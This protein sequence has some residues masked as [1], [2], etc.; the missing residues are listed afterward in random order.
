VPETTRCRTL[1]SQEGIDCPASNGDRLLG[2]HAVL[3]GPKATQGVVLLETEKGVLVDGLGAAH[4]IRG[5]LAQTILPRLIKLLDGTHSV[6]DLLAAFPTIPKQQ[7]ETAITLLTEWKL[8]EDDRDNID[9]PGVNT[10]TLAFLKRCILVSKLQCSAAQAYARLQNAQVLIVASA[11][12]IVPADYVRLLV[13]SSGIGSVTMTSH[14]NLR[15]ESVPQGTLLVVL[16]KENP[17][18]FMDLE[19]WKSVRLISWLRATLDLEGG[20]ADVGPIFKPGNDTCYSCFHNVYSASVGS[21]IKD[22]ADTSLSASWACHVAMEL[23]KILALPALAIGA[24]ELRRFNLPDWRSE[25]LKYPRLP[26]CSTCQATN[27]PKHC[28]EGKSTVDHETDTALV[29]EEYVG[30]ESRTVL[31]AG[32]RGKITQPPVSEVPENKTLSNCRHIPLGTATISLNVG[33]LDALLAKRSCNR[34]TI[35][36]LGMILALTA[37]IR[38]M[39]GTQVQRWAA[40]AGN[41]GSVEPFV[42]ARNVDGLDPGVYFYQAQ[43]HQMALLHRRVNSNEL[44]SRVLG[45]DRRDLPDALVILTG[46]FHRVAHK[47]ASF[48]YRLVSLDAGAALSQLHMVAYGMNIWSKTVTRWPDDL[49]ERHL[50]LNSPGEQCTAVAE[51]SRKNCGQK[52]LFSFLKR[53]NKATGSYRSW[54]AAK[55]LR[56]L[57]T[58]DLTTLLVSESRLLEEEFQLHARDI[59]FEPIVQPSH[60]NVGARLSRPIKGGLPVGYVLANRKSIRAYGDRPIPL[61]HVST[62]LY[63]AHAADVRE[64]PE[65][66]RF[67]LSLI[68]LLL[69]R[70]VAGLEVGIYEYSPSRHAIIRLTPSLSHAQT[71]ELLVQSEFA[72]APL[73]VWIAGNLSAACARHGAYGHRQLLLRAGAAAHRVWMTLLGLGLSGS[74]VAGLIPGVARKVLG[75]D[76]YQ[77]ASLIAIS[78]GYPKGSS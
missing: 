65:E 33:M 26:M 78:A 4:V 46:A 73:L 76:G 53:R 50:N 12:S 51:L 64:W 14:Q 24:R 37:G 68:Y 70:E 56:G 10:N 54:K 29:F 71:T 38:S 42:V 47:Y 18:W 58:Q 44:M 63:Y 59:E 23:V 8:I 27:T 21:S 39:N 34:F 67:D 74:L 45:P 1:D 20:I 30:L 69:V 16:A 57:T 62:S 5:P 32:V 75:L 22:A 2:N 15:L 61:D 35:H 40:T 9:I 52:N 3:R 72:D 77:R 6:E 7:I 13:S 55:Q 66:H 49:I 60:C 36:D 43:N 48:G 28:G 41:L 19:T 17:E 31:D 25:I 11:E